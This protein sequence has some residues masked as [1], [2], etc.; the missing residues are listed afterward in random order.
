MPV[1]TLIESIH[2]TSTV[3]DPCHQDAGAENIRSITRANT[4]TG[5]LY[6][7]RCPQPAVKRKRRIGSHPSRLVFSFLF[8]QFHFRINRGYTYSGRSH[9]WDCSANT[10]IALP[11]TNGTVV[12]SSAL[13]YPHPNPQ[14]LSV[15]DHLP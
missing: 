11:R 5:G 7:P 2:L 4:Y 14:L 9:A 10:R 6:H 15:T 12:S 3:S 1:G 13:D 8:F